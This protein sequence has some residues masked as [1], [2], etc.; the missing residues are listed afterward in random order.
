M[1]VLAIAMRTQPRVERPRGAD[2]AGPD[3]GR[4]ARRASCARASRSRPRPARDLDDDHLRRHATCGGAPPTTAILCRVTYS[5]GGASCTRT[6][7]NPD[8][9]GA[10]ATEAVVRGIQRPAVFTYSPRPRT[11]TYVRGPARLSAKPTATS[12]SPFAT[13]SRFAMTST[14]W[15]HEARDIRRIARRLAAERAASRSS[16]AWSPA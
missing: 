4:A 8:G 6:E 9:S 1:T 3:P 14:R 12:R 5:C 2:P 16:R 7:R 10:P 13:A 11:P 15:A